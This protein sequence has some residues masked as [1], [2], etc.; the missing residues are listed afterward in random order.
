MHKS[1]Y[2]VDL[3]L[4]PVP[5]ASAP[6]TRPGMGRRSD[7]PT[8]KD[9]TGSGSHRAKESRQ[10]GGKK[11]T[12]KV[13]SSSSSSSSEPSTS[14][15]DDDEHQPLGIRQALEPWRYGVHGCF[16]SMNIR[17][18]SAGRRGCK[19]Y[20]ECRKVHHDADT[21]VSSF[22]RQLLILEDVI[23]AFMC[24]AFHH[25]YACIVGKCP[26]SGAWHQT[27]KKIP[28]I[29]KSGFHKCFKCLQFGLIK[30]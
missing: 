4:S 10:K 20:A 26:F 25:D 8:E 7:R 21:L 6:G 5:A 14:S 9:R 16:A 13:E 22:S 12:R 19:H 11:A 1:T 29:Q 30:F 3:T 2:N 15:E 17:G 28:C 24:T 23:V 27:W 18:L